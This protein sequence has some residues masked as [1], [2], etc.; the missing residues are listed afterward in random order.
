MLIKLSQCFDSNVGDPV[1]KN[2]YH[3]QEYAKSQ[4]LGGHNIQ[5]EES[6]KYIHNQR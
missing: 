5:T 3:K 2:A 4:E 6:Q 1:Q